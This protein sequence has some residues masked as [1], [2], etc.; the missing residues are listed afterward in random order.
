[1]RPARFYV[2]V[3]AVLFV[4]ASVNQYVAEPEHLD[5]AA[6]TVAF[7]F[8]WPIVFYLAAVNTPTP[9]A[10]NMILSALFVGL[11]PTVYDNTT[12]GWSEY[13]TT[14]IVIGA[15]MTSLMAVTLF[16][17]IA[18]SHRQKDHGEREEAA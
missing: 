2:P 18:L 9:W 5:R 12:T 1:M 3:A 11:T 7:T 16:Y 6:L 10:N 8:I 17:S 14:A 13:P 15:V 4:A